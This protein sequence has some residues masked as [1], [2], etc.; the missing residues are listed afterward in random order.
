MSAR[1]KDFLLH[2]HLLLHLLPLALIL[3]ALCNL[4]HQVHIPGKPAH[5]LQLRGLLVSIHKWPGEDAP[6]EEGRRQN[7]VRGRRRM[8]KC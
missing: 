4:L 6:N 7:K 2:P 1:E 5:L 3:V 8:R